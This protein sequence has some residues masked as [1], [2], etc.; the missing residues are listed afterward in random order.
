[1][2]GPFT[3][4]CR[5]H[6]GSR[7][8]TEAF[9]QND[10]WMGLCDKKTKDAKEFS[11]KKPE[12]RHLVQEAFRYSEMPQAEKKQLQQTMRE[13]VEASKNNCPDP[14]SRIAYGWKRIITTF[15]IQIFLEAYPEGKAIHLIRDGRDAMLSR[16]RQKMSHLDDP[17][18]R[19]VVFGNASVSQYR[20][21]PLTPEVIEAYRNEIEMEYWV[22]AVRFGMR[23]RM[24]DKQYM[25]VFYEDLCRRPAKTLVRVFEFL[26]VPFYLQTRE[27]IVANASTAR[28]GKWK[29]CG[30]EIKDAIRIGEPLLREL[31]YL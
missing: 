28:I 26:E 4:M 6:S 13:L 12:V 2:K 25:E 24:Y 18:N 16:S 5:N 31:G 17:F 23:G 3:I 11:H 14:A 8:L 10:F 19:L 15:T 27:W 21:K 22:T 29:H 9:L 1:M 30:D 7:L 20:G